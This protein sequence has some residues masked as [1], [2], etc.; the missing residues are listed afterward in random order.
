[1]ET[2]PDHETTE[3]SEASREAINKYLY[4]LGESPVPS[5]TGSRAEQ[6]KMCLEDI[7]LEK[8]RNSGSAEKVSK[9]DMATATEEEK[10][11]HRRRI[12][13]APT[14]KHRFIFQ[15]WPRD[16]KGE[17]IMQDGPER[18][19]KQASNG[20]DIWGATLYDFYTVHRHPEHK[21]LVTL[22]SGSRLAA[23]M[24]MHGEPYATGALQAAEEEAEPH[25]IKPLDIGEQ[26][27]D[28]EN[29]PWTKKSWAKWHNT[30]K[31]GKGR[32]R[33]DWEL[34][35]NVGVSLAS[36]FRICCSLYVQ[37][38]P[39]SPFD[40][41][42]YPDPW[43]R[44]PF[45][46]GGLFMKPP[47][48]QAYIP[49]SRLPA[50]LVVHDPE[51]LLNATGHR[52]RSDG[53]DD[54]LPTTTPDITHVYRLST[55]T[56]HTA[57]ADSD[58]AELAS[59]EAERLRVRTEFLK[60]PSSN[61]AFPSGILIDSSS[62]DREVTLG[63]CQPPLFIVFPHLPERAQP[64]EAHLYLSH[65][66]TI[67]T[68]GH[69]YVYRAELEVPRSYLVDEVMC[70]ECVF[71]DLKKILAEQDGVRGEKRDKR[72][73]F[74]SGRHEF[75]VKSKIGAT[76]VMKDANG[77]EKERLARAP[78][79]VP[80]IVYEG[81]YRAIETRVKYQDLALGPYCEH[82]RKKKIHP[83]T[84][85]VCVAAKLSIDGDAHLAREA[86]NYQAFPRH[87]FEHWNGYNIVYP[88]H[89]PVPVTPVVPQYY[90][91][92]VVDRGS[93]TPSARDDKGK[94]K[95]SDQW[96]SDEYL[97]PILL[98]EDCGKMINPDE[99]SIDDK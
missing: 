84:S 53:S 29:K 72:W 28:Q 22:S 31:A 80:E 66:E 37:W 6:V 39:K 10:A 34:P 26:I 81:P 51:R 95:E 40:P 5:A 8:A 18:Q 70:P 45:V 3:I 54:A 96:D 75:K 76:V 15:E 57:R 23:W 59:Q 4:F 19:G 12:L 87:F 79:D 49:P 32:A 1:M 78:E 13:D 44:A 52:K 93:S 9:I 2:I 50:K 65:R 46:Y 21:G 90:G 77:V 7:V 97:S 92:Y 41:R 43:P 11:A 60:S 14:T 47:N 71:D 64:P 24:K 35:N 83:L 99:L 30:G 68:G 91:Y 86:E 20:I 27:E 42:A 69:S 33:E 85:K 48:L 55:S 17:C 63:P 16:P 25:I 56:R 62:V 88:L 36:I 38:P 74:K 73:D 94:Q 61:K 98:L 82:L 89:D 67:G 58:E